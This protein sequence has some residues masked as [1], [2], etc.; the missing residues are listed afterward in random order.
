MLYYIIHNGQHVG[1]MPKE[2]LINYGLTPT[3]QVCAVG[4]GEWVEASTVTELQVVLYS[5]PVSP[6]TITQHKN[7][8]SMNFIDSIKKCF[9]NYVTF[10]GRARR[11]EYWWFALACAAIM[12]V[13]TLFSMM[14]SAILPFIGILVLPVTLILAIGL[15]IPQLAAGARRLHDTGRSGWWLLLPIT[16]IGIIFLIIWMCEDSAPGDNEYGSNPKEEE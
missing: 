14:V 1:P 11:S 6:Y 2:E 5:R 16:C 10:S 15:M 3:S 9:T 4:G 13:V 12:G 8:E 7:L